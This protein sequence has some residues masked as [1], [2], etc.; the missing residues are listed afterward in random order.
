MSDDTGS[1]ET[2]GEAPAPA[3]TGAPA[4]FYETFEDEGLRGWVGSKFQGADPSVERLANSYRNLEKL[5]GAEKAGRVVELPGPDADPDTMSSFYNRLGRPEAADKYTVPEGVEVSEQ[6]LEAA[7]S[8]AFE[9]GITDKQFQNLVQWD[10]EFVGEVQQQSQ[11]E[12]QQ[13]A[14]KAEAEL[15]NE[16]GGAYD[17]RI[18]AVNRT[19]TSL[20]MTKEQL[21]GLRDSMGPSAAMKFVYDLSSKLGED[22]PPGEGGG[23][24]EGGSALTPEAANAEWNRLRNDKAFQDAWLNKSDPQHNWAMAKKQS[25]M[26]Q[27]AGGS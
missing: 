3:P 12:R 7:R 2:G 17:Q 26:R 1:I 10:A 14:Q 24:P 11:A 27:I 9:L 25:L 19:A 13:A 16:W 4:P 22:A 20:G 6:R 5:V 23:T 18:E 21:S 15:R 8:K